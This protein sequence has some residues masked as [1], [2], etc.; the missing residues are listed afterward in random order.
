MSGR[1]LVL[2]LPGNEALAAALDRAGACDAGAVTLSRFPDGETYARIESTVAGRHVL[3][4]ATQHQP[5]TQF[6]ALAFLAD[7]AR[8]LGA[9]SVG[10]VAPY[11]AYMRQDA[12]FT[13][14][15]AV[16][17]RTYARQISRLVNSLI[18]V[19]PHLH[20]LRSLDAVF[21]I[22]AQA[23][24]AAP[25]LA[26][27]IRE[28][29]P[30]PLIVGPDS[31]SRQWAQAVAQAAQAPFVVL[32]KV[33]HGSTD[34]EV[35]ISTDLAAFQGRTPVLVDDIISTGHTMAEAARHL[36]ARG[37]GAPSCVGVHAVFAT[38][39]EDTLH[40]AGVSRIVTT[41]TI[42]HHTNAIDIVPAIADSIADTQVR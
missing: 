21:S 9:L 18:T 34:V 42:Q 29:V 8:E 14:G 22:P 1:P 35:T 33:R 41:N 6:L 16:A 17:S 37:F 15:E 27:W 40:G 39:A 20:R 25:L 2:P 11:L 12:R 32:E 36:M 7:A 23:I 10:L 4:A 30:R 5:D 19:D 26:R 3:I 31:E 13:P 24:D 38:G 28:Q